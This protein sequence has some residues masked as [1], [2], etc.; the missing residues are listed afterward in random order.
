V[1]YHDALPGRWTVSHWSE[2]ATLDVKVQPGE[3]LQ[4]KNLATTIPIG[5][6]A[7]LKG[8]WLVIQVMLQAQDGR[9]STTYAHS[10]RTLFDNQ[11]M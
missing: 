1:A 7:S 11:R 5:N 2:A 10:A 9:K 3:P 4:L 6:F 8:R